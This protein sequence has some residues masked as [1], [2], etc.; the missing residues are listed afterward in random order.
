MD[1]F[2]HKFKCYARMNANTDIM[3]DPIKK[4]DFFLLLM[5]GR[6]TQSFVFKL[7]DWLD[8]IIE[9][10]ESLP[11]S[12]NAWQ[13]LEQEFKKAFTNYAK[14]EKVDQELRK[15]KMK[16]KNVDFYIVQFQQLAYRGR[17]NLDKPEIL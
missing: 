15:L 1:E 2:L 4:C 17:H 14:Q 13:V 12:M 9:D 3:A 10:P 6:D 5:D 8:G 7:G 11:W 16:D